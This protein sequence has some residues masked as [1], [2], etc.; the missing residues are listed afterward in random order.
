M[1]ADQRAIR[2]DE[3]AESNAYRR[4]HEIESSTPGAHFLEKH[5]GIVPS[6]EGQYRISDWGQ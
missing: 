4:P 5:G 6:R 1:T 3:L 2:L